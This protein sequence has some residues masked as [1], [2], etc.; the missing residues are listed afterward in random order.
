MLRNFRL[1]F[2]LVSL[3]PSIHRSLDVTAI[4]FY[5]SSLPKIKGV[6]AKMC[7]LTFCVYLSRRLG[8]QSL[9]FLYQSMTIRDI[10]GAGISNKKI[11]CPEVE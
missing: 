1:N 2:I 3:S 10:K 9:T 11:T 6:P 7:F 8:N 5:I 4:T